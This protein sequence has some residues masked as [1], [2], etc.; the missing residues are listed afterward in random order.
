M[1]LNFI[2]LNKTMKFFLD[3]TPISSF[4]LVNWDFPCDARD[5]LEPS[6]PLFFLYSK[7]HTL[8]PKNVDPNTVC[9]T[10]GIPFGEVK[11]YVPLIS[12][13]TR[14]YSGME[15]IL[16]VCEY[17]L[18]SQLLLISE[19]FQHYKFGLTSLDNALGYLLEEHYNDIWRPYQ[20]ATQITYRMGILSVARHIINIKHL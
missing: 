8:Q 15:N 3:I 6:H 18:Y 14:L 12:L 10:L 2:V 4:L 5:I 9:S 13:P 17:G 1:D 20:V 11:T 16:H 19:H 7:L